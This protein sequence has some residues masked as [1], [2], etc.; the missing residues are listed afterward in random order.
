MGKKKQTLAPNI[1]LVPKTLD[2]SL[3]ESKNIIVQKLLY[4]KNVGFK[5][6]WVKKIG[7]NQTDFGSKKNLD[8]EILGSKIFWVQ[9]ILDLKIFGLFKSD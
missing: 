3:L 4:P 8:S 5:K 2:P 6:C 7:P 9:Q 1:L